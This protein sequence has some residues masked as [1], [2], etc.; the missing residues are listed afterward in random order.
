MAK[1]KN[2]QKKIVDDADFKEV[3]HGDYVCEFLKLK[4]RQRVK[5]SDTHANVRRYPH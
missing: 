5:F 1:V 3:I 2:F 4:L